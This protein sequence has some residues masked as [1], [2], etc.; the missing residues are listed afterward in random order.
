VAADD[1]IELRGLRLAGVVGVLAHEQAQPQP[2]ELDLDVHL[3]LAS[4]GASDELTD[5][6][7][8]G[9]LCAVVELVVTSTSYAL[10]ER[11]AGHVAEAVLA[12]DVR[13]DAV[14]VSV[15]KLRPP[16]AQQLTTSGVRITRAR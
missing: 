6:V 5:T 11:L 16:V 8:Y 10:L 12:A 14:T 3:D 1:R 15:R 4:A 13:V 9:A 7:D 2:L